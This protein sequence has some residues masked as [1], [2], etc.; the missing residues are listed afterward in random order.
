MSGVSF[1]RRKFNAMLGVA[2]VTM[3]VN[4]IVMLAEYAVFLGDGGFVRL[5]MRDTGVAFD[6]NAA[7]P[8]LGAFATGRYL[9]TLNCNRSEYFSRQ[10]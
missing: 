4:Y 2:T 1:V 10:E 7:L 9:N 6:V 3:S 8:Y 5:V